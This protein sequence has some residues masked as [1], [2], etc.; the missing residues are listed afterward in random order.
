MYMNYIAYLFG[1][2]PCGTVGAIG[3]K[4]KAHGLRAFKSSF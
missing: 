3:K 4:V 2:N 1:R